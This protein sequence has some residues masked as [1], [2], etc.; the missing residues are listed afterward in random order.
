MS[1]TVNTNVSSLTIQ[2]S[3]GASSTSLSNSIEKMST[4][5]KINKAADDAAGL[6]IATKINTQIRGSKV[7]Q[8]NIE[9]GTSVLQ[10]AEGDLNTISDN[11]NRIRD[12]ALQ[13]ANGINSSDSMSAI[14]KEVTARVSEIDR[15]AN[16]SQ[17]NGVHLLNKDAKDI[18]LQVGGNAETD[19]NSITVANVFSKATSSAVGLI[20]G[21]AQYKTVDAAFKAASTAAKFVTDCDKALTN[22]TN[23]L[24]NIGAYQN[25]LDSALSSL[26]VSEQN[27]TSAKSTIMDADIAQEASNYTKNSILQRASATLLAQANQMPSIALT[28]I[29]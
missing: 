25:R 23:R 22:V 16:A 11:I 26:Q 5:Y 9:Q 24:A 18:T 19:T 10:T 27:M 17:F 14:V 1:I 2:R 13:A 21:S 7:A 4:G 15:T 12:L 20:N 6:S 3:L 8:S 28:L 29:G